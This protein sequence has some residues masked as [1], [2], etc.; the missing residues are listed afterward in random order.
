VD[1]RERQAYEQ[2]VDDLRNL[3]ARTPWWRTDTFD[4]QPVVIEPEGGVLMRIE[5]QWSPDLRR[6]FDSFRRDS[7]LKLVA[8]LDEV[9]GTRL[10]KRATELLASLR[11]PG[12]PDESPHLPRNPQNPAVNCRARVA[13]IP[14]SRPKPCTA[15]SG[16]HFRM[17]AGLVRPRQR[18]IASGRHVGVSKVFR[19]LPTS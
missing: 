2:Q 1:F 17:S 13:A 18:M 5:G 4:G 7:L 16:Q 12:P 10:E 11:I 9:P 19:A 15:T 3:I 8:L 14:D 6:F